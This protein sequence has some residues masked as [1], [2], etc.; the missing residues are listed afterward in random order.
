[1]EK[2][3]K[4]PST[5]GTRILVIPDLHA[6]F[7]HR[8]ALHFLRKV[9]DTFRTTANVF[10]GDETDQHA[11]S[12]Y[13][14]DPDGFSGGQ[15][16]ERA[17]EALD[18][19]YSEFA[20][21]MLC[22]SNH[23]VRMELRMEEAGIPRRGRKTMREIICAPAAWKWAQHWRIGDTIFEH[24]DAI[25]GGHYPYANLMRQNME[26]SVCGHHHGAFGIH[27]HRTP[28]KLM[29]GM[30]SGCLIDEDS[31]AFAYGKKSKTKPIL[32]CSVVLD[33]VPVLIK[34]ILNWKGRWTGRIGIDT[35]GG[36]E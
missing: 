14:K 24:G 7:V 6:P 20:E 5:A 19:Y 21:A 13:N 1:M 25:M 26:S 15:E 2:E 32:G 29:F 18:P 10:L 11:F 9:R 31:Y 33:G 17:I 27:W 30:G 3:T 16:I 23:G 35:K 22:S 28:H 34:M 36:N 12:K 8:D 4:A